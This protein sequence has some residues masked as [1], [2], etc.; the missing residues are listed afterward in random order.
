MTLPITPFIT[1][2]AKAA[3]MLVMC[4]LC[5]VEGPKARLAEHKR[6]DHR[7]E[8]RRRPLVVKIAPRFRPIC[9]AQRR[10]QA[11]RARPVQSYAAIV[12]TALSEYF[13]GDKAPFGHRAHVSSRTHWG[14]TA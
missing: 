11:R 3:A 10:M 1:E 9:E 14:E 6:I 2:R 5:G 4:E 13:A 8:K 7:G 12:E